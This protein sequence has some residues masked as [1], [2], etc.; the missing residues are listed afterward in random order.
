MWVVEEDMKDCKTYS[1]T[2]ICLY[3]LHVGIALPVLCWS[4]ECWAWLG[5]KYVRV[6]HSNIIHWL[7][8]PAHILWKHS[9]PVIR[10][11][12]LERPESTLNRFDTTRKWCNNCFDRTAEVYVPNSI[13]NTIMILTARPLPGARTVVHPHS[14]E[15]PLFVTLHVRWWWETMN[16]HL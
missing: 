5:L 1:R 16:Y 13:S 10:H 11:P 3:R 2:F 8:S 7:S 14:V 6:G 15:T 12:A 4:C 9:L